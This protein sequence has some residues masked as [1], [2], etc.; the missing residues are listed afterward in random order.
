M[1]PE[2]KK[3]LLS[4]ARSYDESITSLEDLFSEVMEKLSAIEARTAHQS[5]EVKA[6]GG[7]LTD[8]AHEVEL[9]RREQSHGFER[10]ERQLSRITPIPPRG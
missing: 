7:R 2:T 8:L 4:V 5:G 10:L 9:T 6:L 1:S 3:D